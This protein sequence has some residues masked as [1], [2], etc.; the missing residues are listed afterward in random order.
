MTDTTGFEAYSLYNALKLHFTGNYD[1]IK[2]NGKTSVS[3]TTFSTRKDKYHFYHLSRKYDIE[4]L[5][6]FYIANFIED[7]TA[8]VGDLLTPQSQERFKKWQKRNQSLTYQFEQDII[9]LFNKYDLKEILAV[10][11]DYPRLLQ[12][13]MQHN[14]MIETV[15]IMD[16]LMNFLPM[17]Q[18][19][20][21][22]DI[23]WPKWELKLT[24]YKPFLHYDKNKLK[25]ILK[26]MVKEHAE[27]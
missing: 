12:E 13:L 15:I 26:E 3:R 21:Q 20:I 5:K 14:I 22:D 27:A 25:S 8:W 11:G 7:D 17:W 16:D 19:K 2:Y 1:F 9:Y 24:K 23:I 4:E 6:Q 18:R 10:T